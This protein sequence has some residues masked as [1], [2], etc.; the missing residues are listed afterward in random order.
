VNRNIPVFISRCRDYRNRK[1][2]K[3]MRQTAIAQPFIIY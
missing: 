1:C 2:S 3:K